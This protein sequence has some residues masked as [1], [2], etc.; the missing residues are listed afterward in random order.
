MKSVEAIH[1][2]LQNLPDDL[3]EVLEGDYATWQEVF[4]HMADG[5]LRQ[6]AFSKLSLQRLLNCLALA[7]EHQMEGE[8]VASY[9]LAL[10]RRLEKANLTSMVQRACVEV[11]DDNRGTTRKLHLSLFLAIFLFLQRYP[12]MLQDSSKES[13]LLWQSLHSF[14]NCMVMR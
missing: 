10:S 9:C 7:H 2:A 12:S 14:L 4:S 8:L 1:S 3:F 6:M 11:G 13:S 5:Y